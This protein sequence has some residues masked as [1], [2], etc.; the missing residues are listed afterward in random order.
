MIDIS[1]AFSLPHVPHVS[2]DL[3]IMHDGMN[4]FN[5]VSYNIPATLMHL[6]KYQLNICEYPSFKDPNLPSINILQSRFPRCKV[7]FIVSSFF[8]KNMSRHILEKWLKIA[9]EYRMSYNTYLPEFLKSYLPTNTFV[10]L[11]YSG[12]RE[13]FYHEI[14]KYF[15]WYVTNANFVHFSVLYITKVKYRL[16]HIKLGTTREMHNPNCNVISSDMN[17]NLDSL[18]HTDDSFSNLITWCYMVPRKDW[19]KLDLAWFSSL[20]QI[21]PF[22]RETSYSMQH[23]IQLVFRKANFTLKFQPSDDF[24]YEMPEFKVNSQIDTFDIKLAWTS[25]LLVTKINGYSYLSCYADKYISFQFYLAPFKPAMWSVLIISFFMVISVLSLSIKWKRDRFST[26]AWLYAFGTLLAQCYVPGRKIEIPYFRIVFSVWCLMLVILSNAYTGLIT[27]ELNS[28]LPASHPEVWE[29]LACK[30]LPNLT[31]NSTSVRVIMEG[32]KSHV[33]EL[34]RMGIMREKVTISSEVN[35]F[36]LLSLPHE[37]YPDGSPSWPKFVTFLFK[38]IL[39][40]DSS[41]LAGT[42]DSYVDK[43]LRLSLNLVMPGIQHHTQGYN[44][45]KI[46]NDS[47]ELQKSVEKE[48]VDCDSKTAF[49]SE[50]DLVEEEYR[51]LTRHYFWKKFYKA[52]NIFSGSSS[53]YGL[54]FPIAGKKSLVTRYFWYLIETGIYGRIEKELEERRFL[55]R[56]AALNVDKEEETVVPLSFDGSIVTVFILSGCLVLLAG[57]V[58]LNETKGG[59]YICLMNRCHVSFR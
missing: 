25:I 53:I 42:T 27:T 51:F 17:E 54:I 52:R 11:I 14:D 38:Q 58:F 5:L 9:S 10:I 21:N 4:F 56:K 50:A 1:P 2:C 12:T 19:L 59:I 3:Q 6:T 26:P 41:K 57:I 44:Y 7:T 37:Y 8:M 23:L 16:C 33:N 22:N 48:V 24:C 39:I 36:R 34:W 43:K 20:N 46:Y 55:F 31:D 40:G 13:E 28:P 15:V 18:V 35:C 49:V 45:G 29:D 32:I 47:T 30:K